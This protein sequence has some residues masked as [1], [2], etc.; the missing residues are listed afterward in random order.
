MSAPAVRYTIREI[1][2]W[3]DRH[4]AAHGRWPTSRAGAIHGEDRSW[5]AV[6]TALRKG[7]GG[8]PG[9]DSLARLLKR[10]RNAIDPRR[11]VPELTRA[12]IL[13]WI[14][15]HHAATGD[16]PHRDSGPVRACAGVSWSTVD[17]SLRR[18]GV[19][20]DGGGSLAALLRDARGVWDARGSRRLS[21]SLVVLWAR[22]HQ[23]RTG[24]WPVTT[25]GAVLGKPGETWAA[26]DMA[27]RNGRRGIAERTSLSRLLAARFGARY[28]RGIGPR[29][30]G[31]ARRPART[32][33]VA[34]A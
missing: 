6:D 12:T 3:A 2:A 25:S 21:E 17:R 22:E 29:R 20:L 5:L 15:D 8:L 7:I 14:D 28:D 32:V 10:R 34:G 24:R 16:W 11:K 27:L 26:I 4:R 30:D 1:L 31:S 33:R 9:G 19:R 13:R 23:Q 18:G